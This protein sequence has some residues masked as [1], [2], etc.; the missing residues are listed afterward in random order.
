MLRVRNGPKVKIERVPGKIEIGTIT[1]IY[2]SENFN[3]YSVK[4]ENGTQIP[5]GKENVTFI[6]EE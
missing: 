4:L 6:E 5:I 2:K 1:K 3:G